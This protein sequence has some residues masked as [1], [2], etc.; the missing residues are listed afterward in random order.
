MKYITEIILIFLIFFSDESQ[1]L[2]EDVDLSNV[3]V[4]IHS[5]EGMIFALIPME[6]FFLMA[7]ESSRNA[8][9]A[10]LTS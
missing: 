9:P 1:L 6:N 7:G 10:F 5:I 2:G 3:E 8:H 4:L